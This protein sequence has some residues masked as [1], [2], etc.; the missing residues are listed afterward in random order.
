LGLKDIKE[1]EKR[2]ERFAP[3]L[4]SVFPALKESNGIIES[5]TVPIP[6]MKEWLEKKLYRRLKANCG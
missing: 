6:H 4:Q 3:Y 5:L 1:A 2:L